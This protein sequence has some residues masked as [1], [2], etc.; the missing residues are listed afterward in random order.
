MTSS[1]SIPAVLAVLTSLAA[2]PALAQPGSPLNCADPSFQAEMNMCAEI[3]FET[4]DKEMNAVYGKAI[5]QFRE[6][7]LSYAEEGPDYVG[8]E[9]LLRESQRAWIG[10]RDGL[11]GARSL[12]FYGGSMRPAVQFSCLAMITRSRTEE[13]R[14]LLDE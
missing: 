13:L 12:T 7:D 3:D 14:W 11:C 10:S 9:K 1:I 8:A 5:A 4:A 2:A 6:Q